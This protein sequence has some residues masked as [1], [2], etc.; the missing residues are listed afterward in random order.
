MSKMRTKIIKE[1]VEQGSFRRFPIDYANKN[2]TI[3]VKDVTETFE[4]LN[5]ESHSRED[6]T[7]AKKKKAKKKTAKRKTKKRKKR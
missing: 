5:V 7:M 2:R 3:L 6:L 1:C 4:C